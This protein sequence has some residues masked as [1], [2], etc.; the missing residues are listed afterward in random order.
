MKNKQPQNLFRLPLRKLKKLLLFTKGA[1]VGAGKERRYW[2][3]RGFIYLSL[4]GGIFLLAIFPV[5]IIEAQDS[6]QIKESLSQRLD[7]I[8]RKIEVYSGQIKQK[9]GETISL[10]RQ[11]DILENQIKQTEL[12]I[13]QTELAIQEVDLNIGEKEKEISGFNIEID[14]KKVVLAEY[15]RTFYEYDQV[16]LPELILKTENFSDFFNEIQSL[17]NVQTKIQSAVNDLKSLKQGIEDQKN[18]LE[19][20]K[21]EQSRLMALQGIQKMAYQGKEQEKQNLL[22]Q[23]KG[24]ESLFKKLRDKAYFDIQSIKNQIYMLDGVGI[25]MTLEKALGHAEYAGAKTGVRP[26]FL[27]AILKKETSW[28]TNVGTGNWRR[29]MH[30]R[31]HSAFLDICKRL[32]VDPDQMPVSRKPSYGWGGAMG[33]AQFLPATWLSYEGQIASATGHNPPNPWD[34]DDAF[35]AAGIKLAKNGASAR[36]YD[37]EWKAA[38]IYFAGSRWNKSVYRFYGD[39]V[40]ELASAIQEQVNAIRGK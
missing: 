15:L 28:G 21:D 2:L 7:E 8:Q 29:D 3:G 12:E 20:E 33:P 22:S 17:E 35:V 37:A 6:A 32:G 13:Q 27:L 23:T 16:S 40:M 11:I 4:F 26:A 38:M 18:A 25:S 14:K 5:K 24:Q 10:E 34:I 39:S 30:P 36:T 19:E 1:V 31:D 9:E